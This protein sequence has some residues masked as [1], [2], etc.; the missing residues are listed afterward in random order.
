MIDYIETNFA[1]LNDIDRQ[2]ILQAPAAFAEDWETQRELGSTAMD[3]F[4]QLIEAGIRQ[5]DV[6]TDFSPEMLA[7]TVVGT[8][9]ILTT[10]WCMDASFPVFAKLEEAR[11]M[12]DHLICKA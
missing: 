8:L 11:L 3:S 4:V 10:T 9:N 12:F 6:N 1:G 2:L 5:G 7:A